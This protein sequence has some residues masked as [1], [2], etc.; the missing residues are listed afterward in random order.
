MAERHLPGTDPEAYSGW[1]RVH[2]EWVR[3]CTA[4]TWFECW[5]LLLAERPEGLTRRT[6]LPR[7]QHPDGRPDERRAR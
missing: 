4:R 6:V 3:L 1:G 7:W 2:G 5:G